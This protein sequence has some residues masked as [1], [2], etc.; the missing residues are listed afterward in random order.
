ML[1]EESRKDLSEF[2][3]RRQLVPQGAA[4]DA[5]YAAGGTGK[6]ALV[7]LSSRVQIQQGG[8]PGTP[9]EMGEME[10]E[11][12]AS[13]ATEGA[14]EDP[15]ENLENKEICPMEPPGDTFGNQEDPDGRPEFEETTEKSSEGIE[16]LGGNGEAERLRG[17][18]Q[19]GEV[20]ECVLE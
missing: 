5:N 1:E 9:L 6:K 8:A 18:R 4:E 16:I 15:S 3:K 19:A 14:H 12:E 17:S 10:E 20:C 2:E 11:K 7:A 13:E